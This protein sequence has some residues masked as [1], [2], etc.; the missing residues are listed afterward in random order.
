MAHPIIMPSLG[1]FAAEGTLTA[2]LRPAGTHVHSG[3]PIAEITTEKATFEL[4]AP[5][6][7]VLH[8]V[9][10]VGA[11]LPLEA[12]LGYILAASEEPPAE[13]SAKSSTATTV[14][15][16]NA[17][18]SPTSPVGHPGSDV[19]ATPV[20]RRLAMRHGIDLTRLVGSGPAGRIVEADVL[21]ALA[22]VGKATTENAGQ[23]RCRIR[24]RVPLSGMR[25]TI[26]ERLCHALATAASLTIT[27]EVAADILVLA[28]AH[29]AEKIKK[30][31]P[32]NALFIKLLATALRER[33]ELNATIEGDSILVL[34]EV[35]V[36]F[37][38]PV[39]G[40][41]LVPV[42]HNADTEPLLTIAGA[43]QDLTERA[44]SGRLRPAD[45]GGGTVTITNLGAHGVDAFTPILNPP[46]SAILGIGRIARR[47][48]V[49]EDQVIAGQTC[50]LSLTFDH[51]VTDGVPA[52]QLLEVISRLMTDEGYLTALA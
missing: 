48:I 46:E 6:T 5:V 49:R 45:T 52:A 23:A 9:A 10:A 22:R 19:R 21:A 29:L 35:H 37:A 39:P 44:Q 34:D 36:G 25:R 7:G 13:D 30:P 27:R 17:I 24:Q 12:L 15:P 42:V 31:L 26:A 18:I 11:N 51:R 33:P 38:V 47:P 41:L 32:Y 20:A 8:P 50:T 14:Q 16:V 2:W 40:G 28:R 3:E 4:E 43:V 1:M